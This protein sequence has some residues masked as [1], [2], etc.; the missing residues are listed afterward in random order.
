MCSLKQPKKRSSF[1]SRRGTEFDI[2]E[3]I[4]CN[5][6]HVTYVI[7]CPCRKQYVGR[8]TRPLRVRIR[9][10]ITNIRKGFPKHNLSR[11][12]NEFHHR[13][14]SGLV[15]YGIDTIK[16]NWRGGSKKVLI[17]QNETRWIYRL[18]SL[19]PRGLNVDIDLNCFL[20]N[21]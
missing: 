14:P 9:E 21:F 4:T 16:D 10:H 17:S 13:D 8:T 12:F 18:D 5:T 20:S 7:E 2:R 3:L 1:F 15:F 19:V 6:T 11:H